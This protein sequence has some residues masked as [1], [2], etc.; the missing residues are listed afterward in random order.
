[1]SHRP[2]LSAVNLVDTQTAS[3]GRIGLLLALLAFLLAGAAGWVLP[4]RA[5]LPLEHALRV[6]AGPGISSGPRP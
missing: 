6:D 5:L 4:L 1:M 2:S 3:T